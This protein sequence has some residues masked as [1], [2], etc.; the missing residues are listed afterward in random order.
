[1]RPREE[2]YV[3]TQPDMTEKS[4]I[5]VKKIGIGMKLKFYI[6]FFFYFYFIYKIEF[7]ILYY[8]MLIK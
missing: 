5:K 1:M 7:L 4:G 2:K 8:I 6:I 3:L